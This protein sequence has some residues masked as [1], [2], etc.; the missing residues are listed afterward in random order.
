MNRVLAV[1]GRPGGDDK[2]AGDARRPPPPGGS[3]RR[4]PHRRRRRRS[5][6]SAPPSVAMFSA[7]FA[8]PPS[9]LRLP[10]G[11]Q[12][13]YRRLGRQAV[14][15]A[16]DV[17][18]K[19]DV[20][21]HDARAHSGNAAPGRPV[22]CRSRHGPEPAARSVFIRN[23]LARRSATRVPPASVAINSTDR[24]RCAKCHPDSDTKYFDT[25]APALILPHSSSHTH[26]PT[27]IAPQPAR[28]QIPISCS[29]ARF[30]RLFIG[31][32]GCRLAGWLRATQEA[33]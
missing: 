10:A 1:V 20:A 28:R 14:R 22:R 19:D 11:P 3:F 9:V 26:P 24:R 27:P 5:A 8:A 18:V 7:T 30:V 4:R 6:W 31:N 33:S 15:A 32:I 23:I 25:A 21:Q 2:L 29:I 13:R 17:T 12:H 16:G